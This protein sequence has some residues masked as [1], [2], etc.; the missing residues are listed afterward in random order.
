MMKFERTKDSKDTE[1]LILGLL[2]VVGLLIIIAGR[3][4]SPHTI[5]QEVT[6]PVGILIS[7]ICSAS[8]VYERFIAE[9]HFRSFSEL[10][11]HEIRMLDTV[12]SKCLKL[13]IEKVFETRMEC[14]SEYPLRQVIENANPNSEILCIGNSLFHIMTK[15]EELKVG[16][17]KGLH[18]NLACMDPSL[19][20]DV[21]RKMEVPRSDIL[22]ALER[23]VSL[24]NWFKRERPPGSFELRCHNIF[25]KDSLFVFETAEGVKVIWDLS[26]G[27]SLNEKRVFLF[28]A[29]AGNLGDN[30]ATRYRSIWDSFADAS[31]VTLKGA[32]V[33]FDLQLRP[34]LSIQLE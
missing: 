5:V 3:S 28:A 24:A 26:F 8:F 14:E 20:P 9:R 1:K 4:L 19:T 22:A 23:V 25:L 18:F 13:G 6:D 17:R 12:A 29:D 33:L 31:K 30:L 7:S 2:F 21:L 32:E 16:L 10:L 27:A 15:V 34:L 11:Q